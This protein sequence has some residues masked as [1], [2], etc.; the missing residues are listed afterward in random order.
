MNSKYIE[1][2]EDLARRHSEE[3]AAI[4]DL[5]NLYDL[6]V[7]VMEAYA[8]FGSG[9][10]NINYYPGSPNINVILTAAKGKHPIREALILIDEAIYDKDW[11]E[12]SYY[13]QGIQQDAEEISW[14]FMDSN[15]PS[16][17]HIRCRLREGGGCHLVGTGEYKEVKI[18]KCL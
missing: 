15:T 10:A 16:R 17:L 4:V 14:C 8:R 3:K 9:E 2:C 13:P 12:E 6:A 1:D 11:V 7:E 18:W 5:E